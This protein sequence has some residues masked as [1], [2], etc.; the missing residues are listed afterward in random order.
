[1]LYHDSIAGDYARRGEDDPARRAGQDFASFLRSQVY[2]PMEGRVASP[3]VVEIAALV[4]EAGRLAP[5]DRERLDHGAFGEEGRGIPGFEDSREGLRFRCLGGI[6]LGADIRVDL[7][8]GNI[9]ALELLLLDQEIDAKFIR[10]PGLGTS[11]TAAGSRGDEEAGRTRQSLCRDG[12]EKAIEIAFPIRRHEE[13]VRRGQPLRGGIPQC[14]RGLKKGIFA[15]EPAEIGISRRD[16]SRGDDPG[17]D[18]RLS[19]CR[20][21]REEGRQKQKAQPESLSD[22]S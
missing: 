17:S 7:V 11:G 15:L 16:T 22:R 6:G 3:A 1:M 12:E 14:G 5:R 19:P 10:A 4:G 20:T 13:A 21:G 2:A 8:Q 18:D 9:L